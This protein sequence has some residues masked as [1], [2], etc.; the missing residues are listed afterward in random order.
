MEIKENGRAG[1]VSRSGISQR[2]TTWQR[3]FALV[4]GVAHV[5]VYVVS[6]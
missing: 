4:G 3:Q 1:R 2:T 5:T 6:R